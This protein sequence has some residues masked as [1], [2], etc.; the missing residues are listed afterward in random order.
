MLFEQ[1][2]LHFV[3]LPLLCVFLNSVIKMGNSVHNNK[4]PFTLIVNA[5]NPSIQ[6]A[7]NQWKPSKVYN[8]CSQLES[9]N[10]LSGL[11]IVCSLKNVARVNPA[12]SFS[13]VVGVSEPERP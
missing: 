8:L 6:A 2:Y 13:E 5:H 4:F 11:G 7:R 9:V 3:C 10:K 1:C 12:T